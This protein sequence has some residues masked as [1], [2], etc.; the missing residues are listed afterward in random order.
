MPWLSTLYTRKVWEA[1]SLPSP[2]AADKWQ[3]MFGDVMMLKNKLYLVD[4]CNGGSDKKNTCTCD[5]QTARRQS[6]VHV[7]TV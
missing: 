6:I 2:A 1:P 5:G 4:F 3:P 7:C